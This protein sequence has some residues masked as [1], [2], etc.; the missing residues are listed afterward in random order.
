M[1]KIGV[2]ALSGWT[3][4]INYEGTKKQ[5]KAVKV[6]SDNREVNIHCTNGVVKLKAK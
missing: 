5:W 4:R 1:K 3:T 6:D 2:E